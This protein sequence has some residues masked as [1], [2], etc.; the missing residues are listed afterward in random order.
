M[1]AQLQSM[2]KAILRTINA[3][4]F[5]PE[6]KNSPTFPKTLHNGATPSRRSA[7]WL[8]ELSSPRSR[9]EV[10]ETRDV[11]KTIAPCDCLFVCCFQNVKATRTFI[12]LKE[13]K[14]YL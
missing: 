8:L 6:K 4:A 7:I 11:K 2:T 9:I 10:V 14:H 5:A 1:S 12:A 3:R 13:I